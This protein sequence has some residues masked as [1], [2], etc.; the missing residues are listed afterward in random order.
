MSTLY[1]GSNSLSAMA[2]T[3][4][5]I[6]LS[7]YTSGST[8]DVGDQNPTYTVIMKAETLIKRVVPIVGYNTGLYTKLVFVML[9]DHNDTPTLCGLSND[10]NASP[11]DSFTCELPALKI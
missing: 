11:D 8:T 5:P 1:P 6:T 7:T 3:S 9:Y 10:A 2:L 4:M